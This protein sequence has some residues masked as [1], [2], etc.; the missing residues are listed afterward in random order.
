MIPEDLGLDPAAVAR[1]LDG[2]RTRSATVATAESLTAGLVAA[3]LTGVAGASDVLRG[4][5]VVYATDLKAELAE[6]DRAVLDEHGAVHPQVARMLAAGARRRCAADWGVGLTGVA[7]PRAQDGV[8]PG[9]VHVGVTG[10]ETSAVRSVRLAGDRHEVRAAAVRV[11]LEQLDRSV[12]S[13]Q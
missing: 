7:G 13:T 10:P 4:G 11:A 8:P 9:T 2:L 5:L 1:V 3:T 12:R 6:V